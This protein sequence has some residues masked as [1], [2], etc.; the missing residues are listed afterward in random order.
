QDIPDMAASQ[1]IIRNH[2]QKNATPLEL[3]ASLKKIQQQLINANLSH[4]ISRLSFN[5]MLSIK[6]LGVV[7]DTIRI[8]LLLPVASAGWILNAPFYY[9]IKRVAVIKT[10]GT[11]FFDSVCFGLLMLLYPIYWLLI[12]GIVMAVCNNLFVRLL[13]I[14]MPVSGWIYV[15]WR[16]SLFRFRNYYSIP[17]EAWKRINNL[18]D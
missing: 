9:L 6:G 12:N 5:G 16:D 4:I 11:V 10:R 18:F 15:I 1:F 3:V 8:I 13:I 14:L 17:R 2:T 7:L